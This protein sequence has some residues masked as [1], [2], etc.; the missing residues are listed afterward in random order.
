MCTRAKQIFNSSLTAQE[1]LLLFR[2]ITAV[3]QPSLGEILLVRWNTALF[4]KQCDPNSLSN[5]GFEKHNNMR[6]QAAKCNQKEEEELSLFIYDVK[7]AQ[8]WRD[9]RCCGSLIRSDWDMLSIIFR[10]IKEMTGEIR[11]NWT[12]KGCF[13]FFI[14]VFHFLFRNIKTDIWTLCIEYRSDTSD[15]K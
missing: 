11:R 8:F 14:D 4:K 10:K 5:Q 15:K 6:H 2:T 13:V 3:W 7:L 1:L 9:W 12:S